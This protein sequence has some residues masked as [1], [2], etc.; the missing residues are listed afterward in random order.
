[1]LE[2]LESQYVLDQYNPVVA[3]KHGHLVN[4]MVAAVSVAIAGENE[5]SYGPAGI[6]YHSVRQ[7]KLD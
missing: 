3:A 2:C 7:F 5:L 1:L 4:K 6:S